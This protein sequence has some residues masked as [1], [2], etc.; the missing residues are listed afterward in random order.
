M[1]ISCLIFLDC[2]FDGYISC[3]FLAYFMLNFFGLFV[4]CIFWLV[5]FMLIYHAFF[6]VLCFMLNFLPCL[7]HAYACVQSFL[8]Y[9]LSMYSRIDSIS[10][11]T[12]GKSNVSVET[13]STSYLLVSPRNDLNSSTDSRP[14]TILIDFNATSM[15]V[16]LLI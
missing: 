13:L 5:Y 15:S 4:S 10:T 11:S 6:W 14:K 2:L 7:F 9:Y 12:F 3:I 8:H 16:L 1:S